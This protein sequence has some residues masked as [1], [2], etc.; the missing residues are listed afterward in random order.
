MHPLQPFVEIALNDATFVSI[1]ILIVLVGAHDSTLALGE[2]S[3]A[4]AAVR[5]SFAGLYGLEPGPEVK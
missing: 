3:A 4:S 5:R 2:G 1:L